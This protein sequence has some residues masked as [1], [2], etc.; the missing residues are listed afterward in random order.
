MA[1]KVV[2]KYELLLIGTCNRIINMQVRIFLFENIKFCYWC[3]FIPYWFL[4]LQVMKK[5]NI[6]FYI[7]IIYYL[8]FGFSYKFEIFLWQVFKIVINLNFFSIFK[9]INSFI[10]W[11]IKESVLL[12]YHYYTCTQGED[13]KGH[14]YRQN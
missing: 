7:P 10:Y 5:D 11:D 12:F 14:Y 4:L 9:N 8:W 1:E 3:M 2:T 6:M 13:K